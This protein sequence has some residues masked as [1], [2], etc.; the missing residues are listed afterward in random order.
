[1]DAKTNIEA[2]LQSRHVTEGSARTPHRSYCRAMRP[3]I[4]Q[5]FGMRHVFKRTP[6][7]ADSKRVGPYVAK[8]KVETGGIPLLMKTLF[9]HGGLHGECITVT[10]RTIAETMNSV[11]SP[12]QDAVRPACQPVTAAAGAH[13]TR[14]YADA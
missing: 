14:C 4:E 5:V 12:D 9:D 13:E 11:T 3:T 8:D 2:R 6:N 7:A 1:M 10:G